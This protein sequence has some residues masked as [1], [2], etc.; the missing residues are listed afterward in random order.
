MGELTVGEVRVVTW[1][2]SVKLCH[3]SIDTK[4]YSI[5][6]EKDA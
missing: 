2:I 3:V 6:I 5:L 4:I 1:E